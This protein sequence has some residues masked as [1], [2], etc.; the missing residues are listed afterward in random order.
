MPR[1]IDIITEKLLHIAGIDISEA[2]LHVMK[3]DASLKLKKH[4]ALLS[5]ILT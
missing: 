1:A 2:F 3:A 4:P 5:G